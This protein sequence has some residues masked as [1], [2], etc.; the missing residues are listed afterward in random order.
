M[1]IINIV[2]NMIKIQQTLSR[3][4]DISNT[5]DIYDEMMYNRH[6]TPLDLLNIFIKYLENNNGSKHIID[7]CKS[8]IEEDFSYETC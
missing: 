5:G 2:I 8:Y 4:L 7:E 3:K 1:I 6:Y